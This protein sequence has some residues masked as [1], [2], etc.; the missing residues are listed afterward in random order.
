MSSHLLSSVASCDIRVHPIPTRP[1][2]VSKVV[3]TDRVTVF[4]DTNGRIYSTGIANGFAFT[5]GFGTSA[6]HQA[7]YQCL[8]K[9]GVIPAEDA[10]L[11]KQRAE[12][13]DKRNQ[14]KWAADKIVKDAK[15]LGLKLTPAQRKFI[16][17]A[18]Q[19]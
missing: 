16:E 12:E 7:T 10:K 9:L 15:T 6:S 5:P 4:L 13:I 17:D 14:R 3:R 18:K 1:I 19:H 8:V 2:K 11:H